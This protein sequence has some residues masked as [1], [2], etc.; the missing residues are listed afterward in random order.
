MKR[1]D[2]IR[3]M[4]AAGLGLLAGRTGGQ[5]AGPDPGSPGQADPDAPVDRTHLI[6]LSFDDGFRKSSI[7]TAEI[8]EKHGLKACINVIASA[9]LQATADEFQQLPVGD[10]VLWNDLKKR[11]HEV[12]PHSYRH[13]NLTQMPLEEAKV[14]VNKCIDMFKRELEGFR[15]EESVYNLAYN[16][17]TPELED[18]LHTKFRAIRTHGDHINPLPFEGMFRLGCISHGPE[19]IDQHLGETIDRFLEGPPGWLVYNTHGLDGEGWGP[20]SSG[21]LDELLHR[22]KGMAHVDVL[23]VIP[24]LDT[25]IAASQEAAET[26]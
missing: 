25:C 22:L 14:L 2:S 20:V 21:Y 11:G 13:A 15:A 12:M 16:A 1:R 19:N 4:G 9:H 7:K 17:S 8:Y 26:D 18:W 5:V 10:F 23:P 24:A 3:L 6:T